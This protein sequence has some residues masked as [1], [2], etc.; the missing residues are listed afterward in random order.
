MSTSYFAGCE[1]TAE[2]KSTYRKLAM[3]HHPDRGGSTAVM[4]E[5]N[6]QYEAILSCKHGAAEM[7]AD[8]QAHTYYYNPEHERAVMAKLDE[9]LRMRLPGCEIWLIGKWLWVKGETKPVKD[10][11]KSAGL[12][13]HNERV[14]WY[15]KPYTTRTHYNAAVSFDD[16]ADYYGASMFTARA[17]PMAA[18]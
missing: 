5:I 11:L 4:Q 12:R 7:G 2:I 3:Q 15:W 10:L 18:I 9:L 14:A 16:M 13:W 1:T 17:A 6:R 8:G